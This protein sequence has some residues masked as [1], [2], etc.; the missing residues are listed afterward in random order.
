MGLEHIQLNYQINPEVFPTAEDCL[1]TSDQRQAASLQ[2]VRTQKQ[3]KTRTTN[4]D[5]S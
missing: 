2:H 5:E 4:Y 3:K 1:H